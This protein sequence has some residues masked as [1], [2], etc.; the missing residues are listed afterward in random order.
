[1]LALVTSNEPQIKRE[2]NA[3]NMMVKRDVMRNV[4]LKL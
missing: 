3:E 2:N 4:R 1:M